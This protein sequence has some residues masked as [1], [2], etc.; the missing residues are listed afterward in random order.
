MY[1]YRLYINSDL[2]TD[3]ATTNENNFLPLQESRA[4]NLKASPFKAGIAKAYKLLFSI[5]LGPW[6][7]TL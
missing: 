3:F 5:S 1:I 7:A 4:Y 2:P 6:R